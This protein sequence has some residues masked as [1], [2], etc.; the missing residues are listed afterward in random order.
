[1]LIKEDVGRMSAA[2]PPREVVKA[3]ESLVD[4]NSPLKSIV[5]GMTIGGLLWVALAMLYLWS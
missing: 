2:A 3:G 5:L 4:E 1:M